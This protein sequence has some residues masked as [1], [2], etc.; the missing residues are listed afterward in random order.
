MLNRTKLC[1]FDL[2][3][4][5]ST[6]RCVY[7]RAQAS[8]IADRVVPEVRNRHVCVILY[9][10]TPPQSLQRSNLCTA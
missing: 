1:G 8:A 4:H 3:L 9:G 7:R 6:Y 5:L 10:M 2:L